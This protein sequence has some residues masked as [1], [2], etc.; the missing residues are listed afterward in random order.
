[1]QFLGKFGKIICW[2]PPPPP[3][4]LGEIL[5]PPLVCVCVCVW[6]VC[7]CM[8]VCV[9]GITTVA[10]NLDVNEA[11]EEGGAVDRQV[12]AQRQEVLM[13]NLKHNQKHNINR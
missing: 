5:V 2:R 13:Q 3:L 1:M 4:T 11:G 6:C 9:L 8:C 10:M 12:P 7:V